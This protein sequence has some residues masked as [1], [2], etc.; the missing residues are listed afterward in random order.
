MNDYAGP[1]A[2]DRSNTR[3]LR[4]I[5]QASKESYTDEL[6]SDKDRKSIRLLCLEGGSFKDPIVGMLTTV[7]LT[8]NKAYNA[9]SDT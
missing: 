8:R 4:S 5:F 6:T 2:D 9:L 7:M 3:L 1:S